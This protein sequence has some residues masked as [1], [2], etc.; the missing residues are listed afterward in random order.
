MR[1]SSSLASSSLASSSLVAGSLLAGL[2]G[3]G[4]LG[5]GSL[6]GCGAATGPASGAPVATPAAG[7]RHN[8]ADVAFVEALIPH[9]RT[10][11]A[12]AAKVAGRPGTHVLAEAIISTQRDEVTRMTGWLT[13]W[14]VTPPPS[15]PAP[16]APSGDPVRALAAHQTEAV[17]LAQREQAQGSNPAA[18]AFARQVI[19]SRTAEA[20][21]L[22]AAIS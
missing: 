22:R 16:P 11:I 12:L 6:A 1:R 8:A 10:G 21:Q 20:G 7:T 9:H 15:S 3:L 13:T 19:E 2:L 4:S 5:L 18:L 17:A 14:G